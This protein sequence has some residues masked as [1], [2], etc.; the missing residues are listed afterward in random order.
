M[1]TYPYI[2]NIYRTHKDIHSTQKIL[3]GKTSSV[4]INKMP[5]Y[6]GVLELRTSTSLGSFSTLSM[7]FYSATTLTKRD[8]KI[9][10]MRGLFELFPPNSPT[11]FNYIEWAV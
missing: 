7:L 8:Q 1:H 11:L 4:C 2:Y 3:A 6:K 5:L 10:Y 9:F